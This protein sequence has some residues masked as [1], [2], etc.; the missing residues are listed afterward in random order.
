MRQYNVPEY[1][2]I[3]ILRAVNCG[4]EEYS[5]LTVR[6]TYLDGHTEDVTFYLLEGYFIDD[7]RP[8]IMAFVGAE[9]HHGPIFP[10]VAEEFVSLRGC[11]DAEVIARETWDDDEY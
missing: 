1:L 10:D 11:Y 7:E 8:A 2:A 6:F 3:A 4:H 5:N 9:D